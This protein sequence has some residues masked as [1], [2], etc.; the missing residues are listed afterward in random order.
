[1]SEL[2][3]NI[4]EL[5]MKGIDAI[6]NTA[7]SLASTTRTKM[8]EMALRARRAEI[9]TGF[10]EKAYE[11]WKNGAQLPDELVSDLK[12]VCEL[13][14]ELTEQKTDEK[15][16]ENSES[17]ST[18]VVNRDNGDENDIPDCSKVPSIEF[19][20][21][22][23]TP[24]A[25][26]SLSDAIDNLFRDSPQMDH[27]ADKINSSLDEMGKQLLQFSSDFGKKLSDMA[28]EIMEDQ[29]KGNE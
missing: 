17:D 21:K 9:L 3:Q 16:T 10:G 2:G 27:M 25:G 4:K 22:E 24:T 15:N 7:S 19:P 1:M 29:D 6:G 23:G 14:K 20:E 18:S 8:N 5:V 11:A 13:E 26:S 28:D 12:E